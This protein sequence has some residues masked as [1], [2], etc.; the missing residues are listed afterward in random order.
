MLRA[1]F[2]ERD[3]TRLFF[4]N[5]RIRT[6][7]VHRHLEGG[8]L[9]ITDY[10]HCPECRTMSPEFCYC[11]SDWGEVD[12]ILCEH[13]KFIPLTGEMAAIWEAERDLRSG[14]VG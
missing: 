4:E 2:E 7:R 10:R 11:D 8:A 1:K 12:G 14:R 6:G 9:S 3:Y 5:G 13:C